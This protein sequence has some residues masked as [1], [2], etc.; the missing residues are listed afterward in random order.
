MLQCFKKEDTV[1]GII[2]C[3]LLEVGIIVYAFGERFDAHDIFRGLG[4]RSTQ[5]NTNMELRSI[6][7]VLLLRI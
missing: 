2:L 4:F 5:R 7:L 1:R 6:R 3:S